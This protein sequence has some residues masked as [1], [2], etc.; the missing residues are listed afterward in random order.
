MCA[1]FSRIL[2]SFR[3]KCTYMNCFIFCHSV[4][5]KKD[6]CL[7]GHIACS[8][9]VAC[10]NR[11]SWIRKRL[12]LLQRCRFFLLLRNCHYHIRQPLLSLPNHTYIVYYYNLQ[13]RGKGREREG[14]YTQRIGWLLLPHWWWIGIVA[15][16]FPPKLCL[17]F[18]ELEEKE[19]REGGG[20]EGSRRICG[21]SLVIVLRTVKPA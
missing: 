17:S 4:E 1:A 9:I 8:R 10:G 13:G 15:R 5:K 7:W 3:Y 6:L 18:Q 21:E 2:S 20:R 14:K 16:L 19:L 12:L 11:L